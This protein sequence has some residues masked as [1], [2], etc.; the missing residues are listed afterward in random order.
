VRGSLVRFLEANGLEHNL[1]AP[2]LVAA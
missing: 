2:A 1:G